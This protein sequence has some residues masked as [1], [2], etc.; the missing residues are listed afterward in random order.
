MSSTALTYWQND[1]ADRLDGLEQM[2]A[3]ATGAGP[4]RRWRTEQFN[5]HLFV[6]LVGQFQAFARALHDEALDWL[7]Q[8]SPVA[9][10]LAELA[11]GGRSLDRGN[12]HPGSL[13]E[14]FGRLGMVFSDAVQQRTH[15]STRME[16]L[17]AAVHLR[18]GIAHGDQRQI[19]L[20]ARRGA[21][22]T[23]RS[24]RVHRSAVNGL[25]VDMDDVVA[26]H[27]SVLTGQP[28]PW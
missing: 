23:L 5:G 10:Q 18:N 6:A 20:A 4:G 22:P 7:R 9:K 17:N 26:H 27:V 1:L 3:A 19:G 16:R 25:A 13:G 28:R 12:P 14:D 11:A 8:Q 15:G 2:H 24:Y 21:V